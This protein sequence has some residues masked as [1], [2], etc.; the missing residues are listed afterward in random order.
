M[1][2]TRTWLR[3]DG[4]ALQN[5]DWGNNER[6]LAC[7]IRQPGRASAPLLLLFNASAH[8][9][10]FQLPSGHWQA[11]L[12][13]AQP[14]GDRH[15]TGPGDAALAVPAHSLQ[16]LATADTETLVMHS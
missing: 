7:L 12:D 1:P 14:Q 8:D 11:V 13:T 15:W 10:D 9:V 2:T 3:P 5:A 4:D 16:L 6:T